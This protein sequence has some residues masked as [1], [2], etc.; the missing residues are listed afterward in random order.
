[1]RF[2]ILLFWFASLSPL[3][4]D[5]AACLAAPDQVCLFDIAVERA[6]GQQDLRD[7]IG[8][9]VAIAVLQERAGS[10]RAEATVQTVLEVLAAREPEGGK[11]IDLL[12]SGAASVDMVGAPGLSAV[13]ADVVSRIPTDDPI[14]RVQ[15]EMG[16]RV[17][18][19]QEDRIRQAI[20]DAEPGV[21]ADIALFAASAFMEAD[22]YADA[23]ALGDLINTDGFR[24]QL[25]RT[26]V[27][28]LLRQDRIDAARIA[29]TMTGNRDERVMALF[30]VARALAEHG[31]AAE[32]QALLAAADRLDRP[33]SGADY[34]P[35]ARGEVLA[36]L[37]HRTA[38][39]EELARAREGVIPPRRI[40]EVQATAAL[41]AGDVDAFLA[42]L[43]TADRPA[44]G[45]FWVKTAVLAA[46]QAGQDDLEPVFGHLSGDH[47]PFAL[48]ALGLQQSRSG[49][50]QAA[51]ATLSRLRSLGAA[52]K[53]HGDFRAA[54]ARLLVRNGQVVDGVAL[55]AEGG[56]PRLIAELA[57]LLPG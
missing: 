49:D 15:L 35:I 37:G 16:F 48:N 31:R 21:R 25:D 3:H 17:A 39:L 53:V 40:A 57:A 10:A 34:L 54:L 32:A 55:G 18:A 7:T 23:F 43:A 4:A 28:L 6:L 56:D 38:A 26:A 46:L 50:M 45:G 41:V 47:L 2:L 9:L 51:Q 13:L 42:V 12:V 36:R 24:T 1:M 33:G 22:A 30:M 11:R 8:D 52:G 27:I 29:A 5:E 14:A 19:G 44:E 20:I